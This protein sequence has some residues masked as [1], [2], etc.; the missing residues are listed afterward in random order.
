MKV[1]IIG[2]GN[3]GGA[4]ARGLAAGTIVHAADITITAHTQQTLDR[5]QA[6]VPN[7]HTSLDNRQAVEGAHMVVLAVKPW[8]VQS[9]LEQI[10]PVIHQSHPLLVSVAAGISFDQLTEM[11]GGESFQMVRVIPNTAIAIGQSPTLMSFNS[12]VEESQKQL[13]KAMFDEL[14]T[15]IVIEERLMAA[16]TAVTSC[17]I[18]YAFE[19][20]KA[21]IQGAIELGFYPHV[22]KAMID[23]TVLGAVQLLEKNG[24]YPDAEIYKVCT[25]GGITIKG[26]NE[27]TK[28]GFDHAVIAGLKKAAGK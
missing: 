8:L 10:Y 23:Q 1:T 22:A 2:A 5:I 3:M 18:A 9:V 20:I 28:E 6:D 17:G 15:S 19:Y 13:L 24:T 25:P 7:I 11:L 12:E 26:L 16:G 4:I 27:M 14:G 21:A